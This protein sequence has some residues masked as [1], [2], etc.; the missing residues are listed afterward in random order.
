MLDGRVVKT[1]SEAPYAKPDQVTTDYFQM[2]GIPVLRGRAF[3]D[4]DRRGAPPVAVINEAMAKKLWPGVDPIGHTLKMFDPKSPWVTIVGVV[5]DVHARGFQEDVPPAMYFPYSQAATS[6]YY[7]PSSMTLVIRT[8][9]DPGEM[10]PAVR[11]IVRALD[12]QVP[13]SRVATMADVIARS[14]ASRRFTTLLLGGFAV[15]ALALAGIGIYGVIAYGVSQ[16]RYEIG[17]RMALGASTA[18]VIRR[19]GGG[20]WDDGGRCG[21]RIGGSAGHRQVVAKPACGRDY[22]PNHLVVVVGVLA[23]VAVRVRAPGAA[24]DPVSP[25][26]RFGTARAEARRR[27]VPAEFAQALGPPVRARQLPRPTSRSGRGFRLAPRG[28]QAQTSGFRRLL[29]NRSASRSRFPCAPWLAAHGAYAAPHH[30]S[31]VSA[32]SRVTDPR[33]THSRDRRVEHRRVGDE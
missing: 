5:G 25:T 29:R 19:D 10:A 27:R 20:C 22:R 13:I 14:I 33:V 17:V 8:A 6:A 12:S 32:G 2:F 26:K 9:G 23:A 21:S 1:I 3:T 30:L 24:S 31:S 11:G 16:R 28:F 4:G 18:S 7:Q 15:V